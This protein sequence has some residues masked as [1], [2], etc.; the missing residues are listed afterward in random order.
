MLASLLCRHGVDTA[1]VSPGSRNAPILVA[2][3][4]HPSMT[5]RV[6]IDERSAAFI[7][8]G[9]SAAQN[10]RPV[11]LVCTSGT[12][13][14][15]YAP[16]VAEAFYRNIPLI[17]ITADRP[18]EWIDQDDSQT[19]IQPG[20]FTNFIK[21]TYDIP[22]DSA[23]SDRMWYINRTLNDAIS[24]AT[25]GR[26]GPVHINVRLADPLGELEDVEDADL[27][28]DNVR[29]IDV[30][31]SFK[32]KDDDIDVEDLA[33][34][35]SP[36]SKILVLAGFMESRIDE[37]ILAKLSEHGNIVVMHEAQSN[38]HGYSDFISNIDA[39]IATAHAESN[40]SLQ[41]D[42]VVTVG[43]SLTSRMVKTWIRNL[44]NI[45]HWSIGKTDH[46]VDCFRK[47]TLR[48]P[49]DNDCALRAL[50]DAIPVSEEIG[51][52]EFK[53]NWTAASRQAEKRA[54]EWGDNAPWCDFKA[55]HYL[56][57]AL[58]KDWNLQLSNGTAVRYAQLFN[59]TNAAYIAC[60]RGVS[61]IDG[62]TS[63]AIGA[64]LASKLP[65][66]LITGDMSAQYD[67]GALAC[68]FIP[69][70]FKMIVLNNGGGGIFR[71]IKTTSRLEELE[72]YFVADVNL[73]LDKIAPAFGFRYLSAGNETELRDSFEILATTD[74]C[75]VLLE[76]KTDGK[77]SAEY[78]TKFFETSNT[79]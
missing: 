19:I 11:A 70:N 4:R 39:T 53:R 64:S 68:N 17:V 3:E 37:A 14:L 42:I 8:L 40:R 51:M 6:V 13:P 10:C 45:Q 71:F 5:T 7:A 76:I 36:S 35:L 27:Y 77:V 54:E 79:K 22:I 75:P 61:G 26:P 24:M 57:N 34:R 46:A 55:M 30:L 44:D 50:Y 16:A 21:A 2:F 29:K 49:Y 60:N 43:G 74:T 31:Q 66:L 23:D 52:S 65:T 32:G 18:S 73:P 20:I 33:S 41:P 78:L 47:L 15:N 62:C 69:D 58:P 67:L 59:Y 28:S 72:K 63:T 48:L 38:M 12:A 1:I 9:L 25:S 56:M